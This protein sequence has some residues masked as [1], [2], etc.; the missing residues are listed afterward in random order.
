MLEVYIS[1]E[2]LRRMRLSRNLTT[3]EMA[4]IIGVSRITYESYESGKTKIELNA[5]LQLSEH[6]GIDV[7]PI[8]NQV[9]ELKN[10][11]SQYKYKDLDDETK[12]NS[13][14]ASKKKNHLKQQIRVK[15]AEPH[16]SGA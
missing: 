1:G 2:D 10:L 16:K 15:N 12:P 9:L 14:R 3:A 11:F 7:S 6:C 13:R 8:K 4:E 5:G